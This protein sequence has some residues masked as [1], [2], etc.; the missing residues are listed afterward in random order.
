M[1]PVPGRYT[2]CPHCPKPARVVCGSN[3][4]SRRE[5]VPRR[6]FM[7]HLALWRETW[8]AVPFTDMDERICAQCGS[9]RT[10][11]SGWSVSPEMVYLECADCGHI[12]AAIGPSVRRMV[13]TCPTCGKLVRLQVVR[14]PASD[15]FVR[16]GDP[17]IRRATCE[18]GHVA[19]LG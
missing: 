13:P 10:R 17:C 8:S 14:V 3:R 12:T 6:L 11:V 16:A 5:I 19:W 7:D 18:D 4:T 15:G 2:S 1:L 9:E